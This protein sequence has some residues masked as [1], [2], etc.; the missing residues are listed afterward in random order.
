MYMTLY[1][2]TET[3]SCCL[4]QQM[5]R[6]DMDW[7]LHALPAKITKNSVVVDASQFYGSILCPGKG[8]GN[9]FS[10]ELSLKKII[11]LTIRPFK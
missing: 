11:L 5:A 9:D 1:E 3:V 4:W 2:G 7:N 10:T 6:M 8:V